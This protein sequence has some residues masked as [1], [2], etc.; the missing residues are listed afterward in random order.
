MTRR[1]TQAPATVKLPTFEPPSEKRPRAALV[2]LQGAESDLGTHVWLEKTVTIGRDPLADPFETLGDALVI[3]PG[4]EKPAAGDLVLGAGPS[5]L[6]EPGL[7]PR[8][9]LRAVVPPIQPAADPLP[10]HGPQGE[11]HVDCRVD[12]DRASRGG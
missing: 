3:G 9:F 2:V 7:D 10:G 1:R 6:G 11:S 4:G 12:R 8:P 5:G